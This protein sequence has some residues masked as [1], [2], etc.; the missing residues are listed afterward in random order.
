MHIGSIEIPHLSSGRCIVIF[1]LLFAFS[2]FQFYSASIVGTLLM[3]RP[4]TIK[5]T[6]DLIHSSMDVGVED[7]VYNRDYFSVSKI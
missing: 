1:I 6:K 3:E 2:I 5:S 4:K 7:I